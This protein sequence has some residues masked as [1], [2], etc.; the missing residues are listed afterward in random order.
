MSWL[1]MVTQILLPVLL[2]FWFARFPVAGFLAF[3]LQAISVGAVILGIGLAALWT[4]PPFWVPYLYAAVF[5]LIT[6]WHLVRGRFLGNGFWQA[7]AGP[8]TLVLMV[9]GL[10][11]IG[12]YMGYLA[13]LGRELPQVDT[14]DIAPPF[15]AGDYLVAQGGSGS[16]VNIHLHTLD[17]SVERF[18]PWRGQ[19]RALDIVRITPF[20]RHVEGWQPADP[21]RYVTF[22]TPVLAPCKG[23]VAKVMD[24]VQDMQVP[25][26]D[27]GN[28]VG[29]YVAVDCGD[30]FVVLAHLRQG[31]I[32]VRAGSRLDIGDTL[33]EMGNSGNSSGPH[34]HV[35]A[36]RGLPEEAPLS[37]RPL[38]LTIN[39]TFYVRN[40]RLTVT[41]PDVLV[42]H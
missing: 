14:V 7:S 19:S 3:G 22:G 21:T 26:M 40:D 36:Q 16:L 11:S 41:E 24:G 32:Q 18:R 34:L 31:S 20:G 8:T 12:G 5:L 35:H 13:W 38:A 15:G 23:E 37:G 42:R 27:P 6:A 9:A 10:G 25:E 29:N 30:F 4:M 28:I 39:G 1:A 17:E 2:L 33:G